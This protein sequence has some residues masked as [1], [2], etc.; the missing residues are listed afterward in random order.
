M[1][2]VQTDFGLCLDD[3]YE[4]VNIRVQPVNA[5]GISWVYK[6]Q[7]GRVD[8]IV[9][10]HTFDPVVCIGLAK[11]AVNM[12]HELRNLNDSLENGKPLRATDEDLEPLEGED[13]ES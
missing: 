4:N 11:A 13:E 3:T 7:Y 10:E 5:N 1:E 2:W 9:K 6:L 12:F 8:L